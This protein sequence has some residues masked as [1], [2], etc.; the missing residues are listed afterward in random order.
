[1]GVICLF[2]G[3][4]RASEKYM[5]TFFY[6]LYFEYRTT[7]CCSQITGSPGKNDAITIVLSVIMSITVALHSPIHE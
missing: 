3:V 4:A 7:F 6:I 1:M 5:H 2:P